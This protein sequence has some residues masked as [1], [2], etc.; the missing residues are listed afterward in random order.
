MKTVPISILFFTNSTVRAG[1]EEHILELLRGL[2]RK[3]F[4]LFLACPAELLQKYGDDIPSDVQVVPILLDHLSDFRGAIELA[5]IL[6]RHDIDILHSHQFRPS[7]FASPIGWLCRV[8]VIIE[9]SHS[10]EVWRRGWLK[11]KYIVDRFTGFFIDHY[12]GVSVACARFLAEKK[13]LSVRKIHVVRN[14]CHLE[15]FDPERNAPPG[16]R[17]SLGFAENDPVL[18]VLA[19]LEPQKGHHV[20]LEAMPCVLKQFPNTRL[21]CVGDGALRER[22]EKQAISLGVKEAV[23]FAG[24]QSNPQDWLAL[25]DFS[26]LPSYYEGLPLVAIESL[27]AGRTMVATAVDGTPDVIINGKTGLT[28]PPGNA[29]QMAEAICTLLGNPSLRKTLAQAGRRHVLEN[30]TSE[31]FVR[32]TAQLYLD[33]WNRGA[34]QLHSPAPEQAQEQIDSSD[35]QRGPGTH[36]HECSISGRG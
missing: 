12:I 33:A 34:R 28:V 25:A 29:P 23:R 18:I 3:L 11:S 13:R 32:D 21:V 24:Y 10:C 15:K 2:D 6:R 35:K 1:V 22:L 5:R 7:A 27:A 36:P 20:L 17:A 4:R 9:T 26:V 8:P 31:R 14:G 16:M 19:R 30:F